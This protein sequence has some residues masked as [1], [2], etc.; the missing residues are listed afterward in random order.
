MAGPAAAAA[1]AAPADA[2]AP[3]PPKD[4]PPSPGRPRDSAGQLKH[5]EHQ[6][7]DELRGKELETMCMLDRGERS[8]KGACKRLLRI[9]TDG[10][11]FGKDGLTIE[12][13]DDLFDP[14]R[15]EYSEELWAE[16][17]ARAKDIRDPE[18]KVRF[19]AA[20]TFM[21]VYINLLADAPLIPEFSGWLRQ[22][23]AK[24]V[25]AQ[26]QKE[27]RKKHDQLRPQISRDDLDFLVCA[28]GRPEQEC[29]EALLD[30]DLHLSIAE[31]L[32]TGGADPPVA[33]EQMACKPPPQWH[34]LQE[35]P[36]PQ[37]DEVSAAEEWHDPRFQQQS[38]RWRDSAPSRRD[39]GSA[40]AT[41]SAAEAQ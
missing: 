17:V 9:W 29:A 13:V 7:D 20:W 14:A 11:Y 25:E 12:A 36:F 40:L 32:L 15:E 37:A 21:R 41:R 18:R 16:S 30:C 34:A 10:L 5:L 39:G 28:T 38:R 26:R 6:L 33:Q 2:S 31:E 8:A 23:Q 27:R 22:K 24:R 1:A 19:N 4:R 35:L 3:C